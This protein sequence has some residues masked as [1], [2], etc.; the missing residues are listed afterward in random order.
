VAE[1]AMLRTGAFLLTLALACAPAIA[2]TAGAGDVTNVLGFDVV[3][4]KENTTPDRST[5]FLPQPPD[6]FR[7]T[8]LDLQSY[9][10]IAFDVHQP[11]RLDTVPEWTWERRYDI[12]AKA[13]R[14]ITEE[15]RMAML[16]D[17]LVTRFHMKAH[18]EQRQQTVYVMTAAH[19]DRRT[20]PGLKPRPDC[21][22]TACESSGSFRVEGL[23]MRAV[24]LKQ[25]ADG[26]LSALARR[27][28]IDETGIEGRFDVSASFRLD[29]TAGDPNDRRPSFFTAMQEQLGLK[30][31]TQRR[32]VDVLVI[33]HIE[34]P[35][36]D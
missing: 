4:V 36:P 25:L 13:S 7:Q 24:T 22:T 11:Q 27:L 10:R 35:D 6:G 33:D 29:T 1:E 8:N 9:I 34:R 12:V 16:R 30:L 32:P 23:E 3:S 21:A 18:V 5:D 31:E 2:Q 26:M 17:V 15:E 28:V 14:P 19:A 20:G